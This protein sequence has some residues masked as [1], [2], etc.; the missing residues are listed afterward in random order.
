MKK[1]DVM[2]YYRRWVYNALMLLISDIFVL[3]FALLLAGTIRYFLKDTHIPPS[4]GFLLVP[5]WCVGAVLFRIAPS[6]GL[7]PVEE[8]RRI[9]ILL[10]ALFGI[11][12]IVMFLSKSADVTSR[13]KYLLTYLIAVPLI[14]LCR[15]VI[16]RT[17]IVSGKWGV[18]TVVYGTNPSIAH[19]LDVITHEQG[20]GFI[21]YGIFEDDV[22][23]GEKRFGIPVLGS[24]HES[25]PDAPFAIIGVQ[26]IP[27]DR[28]QELLE[29]P[30]A[31][32]RRL[33]LIPDLL[34]IPSLWVTAHDFMGV[35]GL[36]LIRNLLNPA[37]RGIKQLI[38]VIC[39]VGLAPLWVP[40]C[41][42]IAFLIWIHD[43]TFPFYTQERV[44]RNGKIFHTWKFRSMVADAERILEEQLASDP[45]LK[46]E[47]VQHRKL[48]NDPR[49]T[50]LG[51]WLRRTS[52]DELPQLVNVLRREMS[53]VGP[54]PLPVYHHS[55]LPIHVREL[56]EQVLP[57][58]TGLWQVSGRSESGTEGME[59]WDAYYVRNWSVWLDAVIVVRTF[60]VVIQSRGAY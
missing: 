16:K 14:P 59:R 22:P 19:V 60:R 57:G 30:L 40:L 5:V 15:I 8:L 53:L 12:T 32:Y 48:R 44:G 29:G 56:R 38:E 41:A 36:E 33:I 28:L 18:N 31:N 42:I 1:N 17:L 4:R 55:E 45:A 46:E 43:R 11:A 9:Q 39:V 6:W 51:R 25:A 24:M 50:V 10:V 35:L 3:I 7:G 21:P 52:L 2:K 49:V 34:E 13:I 37:A 54:R 23:A 20:L 27:R 26:R 47:W 58:M